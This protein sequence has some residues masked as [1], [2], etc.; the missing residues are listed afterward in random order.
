MFTI[1]SLHAL[2]CEE[3][4]NSDRLQPVDPARTNISVAVMFHSEHSYN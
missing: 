3:A 4:H 1:H 2:Q